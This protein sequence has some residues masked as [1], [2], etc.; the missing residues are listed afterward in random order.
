[1]TGSR[2]IDTLVIDRIEGAIE[3]EPRSA[4]LAGR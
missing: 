4:S 2:R 1:M 3:S